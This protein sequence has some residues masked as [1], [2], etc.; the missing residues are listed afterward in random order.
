MAL[1]RIG[2]KIRDQVMKGVGSI[3]EA[4]TR[5]PPAKKK[6]DKEK[7]DSMGSAGSSDTRTR[8]PSELPFNQKQMSWLGTA[9]SNVQVASLQAFGEAVEERVQE[10]E[11]KVDKNTC[12]IDSLT[13]SVKDLKAELGTVKAGQDQLSTQVSEVKVAEGAR[14]ANTTK[15]YN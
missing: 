1:N 5:S 9:V 6:K 8:S 13:Q 4:E 3:F 10:V 15:A 12:D 11:A 14:S 2:D 7:D